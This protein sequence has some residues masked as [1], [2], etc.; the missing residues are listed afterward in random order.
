MSKRFGT[1]VTVLIKEMYQAE[2]ARNAEGATEE[3]RK[4]Y[5]ELSQDP[6]HYVVSF[7]QTCSENFAKANAGKFKYRSTTKKVPDVE[8]DNFNPQVFEVWCFKCRTRF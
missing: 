8:T 1:Y 3:D 4:R 2:L 5:D 6:D 7:I